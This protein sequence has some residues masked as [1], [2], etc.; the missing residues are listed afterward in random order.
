MGRILKK[1]CKIRYKKVLK[2]VLFFFN[3]YKY[4]KTGSFNL[5]NI[6]LKKLHTLVYN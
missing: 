2:I 4:T 3:L 1:S 6:N 5:F